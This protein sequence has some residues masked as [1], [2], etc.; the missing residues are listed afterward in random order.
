M[1]ENPSLSG[2]EFSILG[3]SAKKLVET[4][5]SRLRFIALEPPAYFIKD[6]T[7]YKCRWHKALNPKELKLKYSKINQLYWMISSIINSKFECRKVKSTPSD[8]FTLFFL[9]ASVPYLWHQLPL[10]D[11]TRPV[12]CCN[13]P[14]CINPSSQDPRVFLSEDR[15]G[16]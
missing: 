8:I 9:C 2:E 10:C 5:V 11:S 1:G 3:S 12:I 15:S 6:G 16:G 14:P 13:T 7:G 4:A